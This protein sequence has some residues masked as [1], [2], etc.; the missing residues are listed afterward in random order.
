MTIM[1]KQK[2]LDLLEELRQ[3]LNAKAYSDSPKDELYPYEVGYN[4]ALDDAFHLVGEL[5]D[6]IELMEYHIKGL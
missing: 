5:S 6:K 3:E 1:P 4:E 2:V